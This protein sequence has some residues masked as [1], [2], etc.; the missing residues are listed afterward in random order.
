[1]SVSSYIYSF[2]HYIS[3]PGPLSNHHIH[4]N[5]IIHS[6]LFGHC[7]RFEK[8]SLAAKLFCLLR[9]LASFLLLR[10]LVKHHTWPDSLRSFSSLS[11]KSILFSSSISLLGSCSV[12][13]GLLV[14]LATLGSV[15]NTFHEFLL[16]PL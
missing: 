3:L 13:S 8:G 10:C 5:R 6:E 16:L 11:W 2:K 9:C 14:T 1:M 7:Q 12:G 4:T 15:F